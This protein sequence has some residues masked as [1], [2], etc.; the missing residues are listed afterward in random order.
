[1]RR[2]P[3]G[4]SAAMLRS[5]TAVGVEQLLRAIAAHPRLEQ[6]EMLGIGARRRS[7]ESGGRETCLRSAGRRRSSG[8]SSPSASP[9]RSSATWDAT[10]RRRVRAAVWMSRIGLQHARRA[11]APS[12]RAA[13]RDRRL[14]RSAA[15]SRSRAAAARARCVECAPAP[16]GSRSCSR[17]GAGSAAPRRRWPGLRNLFECHAVASGPV[18][19]SP[20]PITQAAIRSGLSNTAPKAWLNE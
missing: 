18:S 9:G 17:S 12:P 3:D 13:A 14:R 11:S 6:P 8:R 16:S 19:A 1:M 15:P 10:S 5:K 2:G 20:S 4:A 7:A